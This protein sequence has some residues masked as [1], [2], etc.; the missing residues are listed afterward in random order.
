MVCRQS[1]EYPFKCAFFY[2]DKVND[3]TYELS[4]SGVLSKY[5]GMGIGTYTVRKRIDIIKQLGGKT[6]FT[7]IS[8]GN[9]AS[10]RR[11][12]KEGF[13]R[14]NECEIRNLPLL[15]GEHKFFKWI[16]EL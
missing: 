7:W 5:T 4:S 13:T 3:T 8:E 2:I 12:L 14:T 9:I 1:G 10:Y 6:C 15:G 11:F 16:K